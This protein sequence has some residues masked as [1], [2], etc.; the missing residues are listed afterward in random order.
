MWRLGVRIPRGAPN[1]Q[2]RGSVA[3]GSREAP[4]SGLII[5]GAMRVAIDAV[6]PTSRERPARPLLMASMRDGDQDAGSCW[7]PRPLCGQ[8]QQGG[9]PNRV[10]ALTRVLDRRS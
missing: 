2:V 6:R 9:R 5:P 8:A 10:D 4:D 3:R 1:A 7:A